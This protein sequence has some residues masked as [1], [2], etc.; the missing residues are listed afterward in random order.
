MKQN[1]P[2]TKIMTKDPITATTITSLRE[3]AAIFGEKKIHHLPVVDGKKLVGMIAYSDLLRL[4]FAD[5]FNQDKK[6]VLAYLDTT[7]TI[8]DVMS[9]SVR[10]INETGTIRQTADVLCQGDFHAICVVNNRGE[11]TGIVT[12]TDLIRHLL[13]LF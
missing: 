12:S 8:T 6:D 13:E 10:T 3:I 5:A 9:T 2:V 1:E 4:S 11:L 7:K